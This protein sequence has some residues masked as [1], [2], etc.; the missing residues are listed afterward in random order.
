[1]VA[2]IK[3]FGLSVIVESAFIIKM[4]SSILALSDRLK[5]GGEDNL[6]LH[7]HG[8]GPGECTI[9]RMQAK[10]KALPHALRVELDARSLL[11]LIG[12]HVASAVFTQTLI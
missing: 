8:G 9:N 10:R 6:M 7:A 1:M 12:C 5:V 4:P 11:I 3:H 2:P